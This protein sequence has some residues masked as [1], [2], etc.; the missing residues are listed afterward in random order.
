MWSEFAFAQF[1]FDLIAMMQGTY[2]ASRLS[3][4]YGIGSSFAELMKD[5][6]VTTRGK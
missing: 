6:G 3:S 4:F 1:A 5:A 2:E